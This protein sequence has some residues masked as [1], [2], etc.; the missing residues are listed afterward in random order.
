VH[1]LYTDVDKLGKVSSTLAPIIN[2]ATKTDEEHPS[3]M[4]RIMEGYMNIHTNA[5]LPTYASETFLHKS[6]QVSVTLNTEAKAFKKKKVILYS[7]CLVNFNKPNI[8]H[9][10]RAVLN[11]NGVEVRVNYSQCCGMPQL[12]SGKVKD[13]ANRAESIALELVKYIDEGYDIVTPVASCSLMLKKEWPL[14]LPENKNVIKLSQN[15]YDISEYVVKI[16]KEVGLVLDLKPIKGSVTLHHACHSR[17]QTMGFKSREMLKLI[18]QVNIISIERCSG[19]GGSFGV[20]T[21]GFKTAMKVGSPVFRN[22]LSNYNN[23]GSDQDPMFIA[24]DCPLAVDHIKQGALGIAQQSDLRM[25]DNLLT[26][27]PIELLAESYGLEV[28]NN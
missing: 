25:G 19:H 17:A 10:S 26:K 6:K 24:S 8:G 21:E 18:P 16:S 13:V 3:L 12:E 15:T 4:R 23:R 11:H 9:A 22:V 20:Q 27:H 7:T 2:W 1:S 14:L 5:L 28:T